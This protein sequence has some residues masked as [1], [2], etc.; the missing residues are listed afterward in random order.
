MKEKEFLKSAKLRGTSIQRKMLQAL[1]ESAE[2]MSGNELANACHGE[3]ES[4]ATAH[5]FLKALSDNNLVQ[6]I[7]EP[8]DKL[9]RYSLKLPEALKV[10]C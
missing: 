10:R 2:P 9:R 3:I 5:A 6:E 7:T 1:R 4:L 8:G